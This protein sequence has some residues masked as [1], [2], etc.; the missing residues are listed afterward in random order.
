MTVRNANVGGDTQPE[1]LEFA[2]HELLPALREAYGK[3]EDPAIRRR[4]TDLEVERS[5]GARSG[6]FL[7]AVNRTTLGSPPAS[8]AC[9]SATRRS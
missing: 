7:R 3:A 4:G 9:R 8:T 5:D 6:G 1:F 2:G